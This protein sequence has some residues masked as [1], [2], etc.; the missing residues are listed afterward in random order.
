MTAPR[1]GEASGSPGLRVRLGAG[2]LFGFP[3]LF[4]LLLLAPLNPGAVR[5]LGVSLSWWY[6]GALAPLLVVLITVGCLAP[7][8]KSADTPA[9]AAAGRASVWMTPALLFFLPVEI[10]TGGSRGL[11]IVLLVLIAPLLSLLLVQRRGEAAPLPPA[12][13][14]I[15]ALMAVVLLWANLLLVAD[16]ARWLG[17]SRPS[18]VLAAAAAVFVVTTWNTSRRWGPL[19]APL[20]LLA[21]LLS[22]GIVAASADR[23]PVRAWSHAASLPAFRFHPESPWVTEGRPVVPRRGTDTLLFEEEHRVTTLGAG[24]LRILVS[25]R[26]EIQVQEWTLAAGQSVAVRPGD[27]LVLEPGRRLRFE[28]NKRIPGAPESG[29]RWADPPL[30][31]VGTGLLSLLGSGLTLLGGAA[32]LVVFQRPLFLSRRSVAVEGAGYVL[33]LAWALGLATYTASLAPELFLGG[34]TPE[35]LFEFPALALRGSPW[36]SALGWLLLLGG[37]FALLASASALRDLLARGGPEGRDL[38]LWGGMLAAAGAG[39]VWPLDPWSALLIA[40][41]LGASTLAPLVWVGA[42]GA[43]PAAGRVALGAGVFVFLALAAA[44]Q[45]LQVPVGWAQIVLGY[46][47]LV[48]APVSAALLWLARRPPG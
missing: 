6:A 30:P 8:G 46:P 5:V 20:G 40:F 26:E 39:S 34:V 48:A 19:L 24:P 41:G 28:A 18:G 7:S 4:A 29:V 43:H 2:A 32:A 44:G 9:L 42:P 23:P 37:C 10:L 21:L 11:W 3:L 31:S 14:L 27:R 47:A 33:A 1:G 12:S 16:V 38:G 36:R 13:P 35:K 22:L 25:D 15:L 17:F 45:L